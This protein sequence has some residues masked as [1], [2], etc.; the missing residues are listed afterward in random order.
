MSLITNIN[1]NRLQ[2]LGVTALWIAC[3][4]EEIFSPE[5]RESICILERTYEWEDFMEEENSILKILKFE[6]TYPL[7][8]RYYEILRIEFGI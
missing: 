8:L 5:V 3:K 2:L 1:K 6:V 4:Y 7:A